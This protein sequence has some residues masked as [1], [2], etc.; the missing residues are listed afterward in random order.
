MPYNVKD[1]LPYPRCT[2]RSPWLVK[3]THT[4]T[5][6]HAQCL[7]PWLC[8]YS[9]HK[10][11]EERKTWHTLASFMSSSTSP[12]QLRPYQ[13]D[14]CPSIREAFR[15]KRCSAPSSQVQPVRSHTTRG[16]SIDTD[17]D[18][19]KEKERGRRHE[20]TEGPQKRGTAGFQFQLPPLFSSTSA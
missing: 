6:A 19:E 5:H 14:H 7:G 18:N 16:P 11:I 15:Q 8:A 2:N 20:K 12:W 10:P 9:Y 4:N 17:N 3:T 13:F 1:H